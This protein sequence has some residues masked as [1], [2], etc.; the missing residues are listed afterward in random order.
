MSIMPPVSLLACE[1]NW[2]QMCLHNDALQINIYY[3]LTH[4]V[5]FLAVI[6]NTYKIIFS[7]DY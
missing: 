1:R 2:R 5:V 4:Y 7:T 6:F 3:L